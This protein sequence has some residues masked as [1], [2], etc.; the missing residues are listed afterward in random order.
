MISTILTYII[1]KSLCQSRKDE[2]D[3]L[4]G[5]SVDGTKQKRTSDG[6][7]VLRYKKLRDAGKYSSIAC[8]GFSG[9]IQLSVPNGIYFISFL[10]FSTWLAYN[11]QLYKMFALSLKL[12]SFFL[13]IHIV[14]IVLF[15]LHWFPWFEE[16]NLFC[17]LVGLEVVFPKSGPWRLNFNPELN[18][19]VYLNPLVLVLTYFVIS[20][21]ST[22][23]LVNNFIFLF[24][25]SISKHI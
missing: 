19:T 16:N 21:T 9:V 11:R 12:I 1:L 2:Q 4:K 8:L 23:L 25:A 18:I 13:A 20:T 7:K 22:F 10:Y 17:Q 6:M 14:F 15:Q 24:I 3:T 5:I